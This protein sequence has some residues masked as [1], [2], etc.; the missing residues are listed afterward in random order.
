MKP[1]PHLFIQKSS[2]LWSKSVPQTPIQN[3]AERINLLKRAVEKYGNG[4]ADADLTPCVMVKE[5]GG[6]KSGNKRNVDSH[7][8]ELLQKNIRGSSKE[9]SFRFFFAWSLSRRKFFRCGL[10]NLSQ[11]LKSWRGWEKIR[12]Y[13]GQLCIRKCVGWHIFESVILVVTVADGI[14][15]SCS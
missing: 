3:K 9:L 14:M 10:P 15:C 8:G 6:A 7:W 1:A 5:N 12:P 11:C 13:S 4:K 2:A